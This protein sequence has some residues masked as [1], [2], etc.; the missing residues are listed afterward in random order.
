MGPSWP[1]RE[2]VKSSEACYDLFAAHFTDTHPL[3]L[4]LWILGTDQDKQGC[5]LFGAVEYLS[6]STV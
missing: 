2:V 6:M 3:Q 4:G 5:L 1:L